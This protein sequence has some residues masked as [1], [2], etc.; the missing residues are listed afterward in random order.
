MGKASERHV[1]RFPRQLRYPFEFRGDVHGGL[2][3]R[4]LS[5]Q[6]FHATLP[7]LAQRGPSG[8]FPRVVATMAALRFLALR[9]ASLRCLH[10]AAPPGRSVFAPGAAERSPHGPGASAWP[11]PPAG[12]PGGRR[13]ASQVPG[14]PSRTCPALGPRWDRDVR[15]FGRGALLF[16]AAVWPSAVRT[17]SAPTGSDLGAESRG[18]HDRCLRF[19]ATVARV[20]LHGRARLASGWWPTLAGQ[21]LNLLGSIAKFQPV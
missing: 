3:L 14:E 20:L 1:G 9:P 16:G 6:R 2:R 15:P 12:S 21:D 4:H 13:E 18:L 19:A 17:A 10:S 5:L 7:P 8:R 11:V